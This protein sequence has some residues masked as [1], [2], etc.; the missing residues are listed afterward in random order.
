MDLGSQVA[1]AINAWLASA[2]SQ[3]L[4]PALSGAGE[5]LIRTPAFDTLAPVRQSWGVVRAVAD[6][7]FVVAWLVAGVLVMGSGG[8]DARYTAKTLVPRVAL[9][10]ILANA[11]LEICGALIHLNNALVSALLGPM[12]TGTA[13]TRLA[14]LL[15]EGN[16]AKDLV[17]VIVGLAAA[18]IALLLIIV[19][20]GRAL[21]LLVATVLAPLALAAYALP[22]TA[23]L[24]QL[25]IRVFAALLFVQAVQAVL[26]DIGLTLVANTG[27]LGDP[28]SGLTT[29]LVVVTLLY[30]LLRLPFAAYEF[31]FRRPLRESIV[32]RPI[33]FAAQRLGVG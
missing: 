30:L 31:A 10:A 18:A 20:V 25:W 5:L 19:F 16:V 2:A 9:A 7:L 1:E 6:G 28:V 3:I 14:D 13:L 33:A 8:A 22:Q 29:S 23:E 11:S 17:A 27:W 4:G 32:A 21:V 24:A 26:L 15:G 12:S